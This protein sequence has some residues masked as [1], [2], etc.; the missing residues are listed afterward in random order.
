M[1][2]ALFTVA[3]GN[4]DPARVEC[5]A[6]FISFSGEQMGSITTK[7]AKGR[8]KPAVLLPPPVSGEQFPAV[9]KDAW[10]EMGCSRKR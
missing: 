1:C 6:V 7:G 4:L 9:P 10:K 3:V 2:L 8:R 5:H